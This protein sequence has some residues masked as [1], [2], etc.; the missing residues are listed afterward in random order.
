M[1]IKRK[2]W[3][4]YTRYRHRKQDEPLFIPDFLRWW[5]RRRA[6]DAMI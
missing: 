2:P 6:V 4:Y 3:G 5:R 1:A